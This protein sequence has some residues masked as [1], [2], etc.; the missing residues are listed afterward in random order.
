[1]QLVPKPYQGVLEVN[2]KELGLPL[3]AAIEPLASL[4]PGTAALRATTAPAGN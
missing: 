2:G 1:M 3:L 4:P